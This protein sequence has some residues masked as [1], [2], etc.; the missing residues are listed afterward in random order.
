MVP[1]AGEESGPRAFRIPNLLTSSLVLLAPQAPSPAEMG[2]ATLRRQL[3]QEQA[4][5]LPPSFQGLQDQAKGWLAPCP[6]PLP[7]W[8]TGSSSSGIA[9]DWLQGGLQLPTFQSTEEACQNANGYT[10]T[11]L[12][13]TPLALGCRNQL[14]H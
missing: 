7:H 3:P 9:P 8:G 14:K 11:Y 4:Q 12:G 13:L 5:H 1:L 10:V 2:W 6:H